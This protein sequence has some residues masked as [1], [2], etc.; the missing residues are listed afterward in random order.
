[1][2][3]YYNINYSLLVLLLTPTLL[4]NDVEK[5]LITSLAK[6]LDLLNDRFKAYVQSLSTRIHA[7][8]C[9]LQALLNDEF[10]YYS[11]RIIV[12]NIPLATSDYLLRSESSD[13]PLMLLS[14]TASLLLNRNGQMG[15]NG[16]DFE[17]VLPRSWTLS[18][19]ESSRMG[20]II[21][22]NKLA[23]KKYTIVYE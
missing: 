12:R 23:S 18:A 9:F 19:T 13:K 17:V 3:K 6:P 16:A 7:Q 5:A 15:S 2:K 22:T 4:R 11:R 10:D 20:R 8:T 1:M 21:N 14:G